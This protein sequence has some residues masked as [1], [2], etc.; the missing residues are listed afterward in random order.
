METTTLSS[1]VAEIVED[2]KDAW[3]SGQRYYAIDITHFLGDH[4]EKSVLPENAVGWYVGR[5]VGWEAVLEAISEIGWVLHTW[6]PMNEDIGQYNVTS[7][8]GRA[9]FVRPAATG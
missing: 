4:G 8:R 7:R 1:V 6:T 3:A 2:S 5:Q 9:L